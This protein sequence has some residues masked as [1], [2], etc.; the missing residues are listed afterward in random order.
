MTAWIL[1]GD[2]GHAQLFSA[3]L[4]EDA[5]TL[6]EKFENPAGCERSREISD[7]GPPGRAKQSAAPGAPHAALEPRTSPKEA[8]AERFAQQL[9]T[10][11]EEAIAKRRY[12][13]LVLVAPPHF[14]GQLKKS[15]GR[16]AAKHLRATVDKDL[17]ALDGVA[18]RERLVDEVF[19]LKAGRY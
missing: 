10:F 1:V 5:W 6:V 9:S 3:E 13:S 2:T 4:R 7:D 16:Q 15:L 17:S 19:P 11:F 14:L 18:A 12:D 8:E